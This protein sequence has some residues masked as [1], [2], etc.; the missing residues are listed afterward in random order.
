MTMGQS[1]RL[2]KKG[3]KEMKILTGTTRDPSMW[4]LSHPLFHSLENAS[5]EAPVFDNDARTCQKF[6][7]V[8]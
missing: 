1:E 4:L 8:P 5:T 2:K 6:Q 3:I 7:T